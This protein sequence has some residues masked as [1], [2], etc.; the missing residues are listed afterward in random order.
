MPKHTPHQQRE[1]A[2][3]VPDLL[4]GLIY[5]TA[6]LV[7]PGQSV[8]DVTGHRPAADGTAPRAAIQ[9]STASSGTM[10]TSLAL[11]FLPIEATGAR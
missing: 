4:A 1:A 3:R 6:L 2:E 11:A 10:A 5:L 7:P 9:R 8:A